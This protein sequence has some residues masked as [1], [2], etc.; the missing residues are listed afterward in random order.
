[1]VGVLMFVV[2]VAGY[3]LFGWRFGDGA[4][5][6]VAFGLALVAVVVAVGVTLRDY[7]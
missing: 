2:A 4:G 7:L 5:N 3:V 6:P 1:M